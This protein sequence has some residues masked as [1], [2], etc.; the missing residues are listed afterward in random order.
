M[1]IVFRYLVPR[2]YSA[3][4]LFPFIFCKNNSYRN[5]SILINHE[6]IHLRQQLELLIIF[7]YIWYGLEYLYRLI[8][9]KNKQKAYY[10]ISFE[11]EAYKHEK[12]SN[13]LKTRPLYN[14]IKFI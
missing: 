2:N 4:A 3:I 8:L 10:S 7:F 13:Y 6:R 9:T 5:D 1:I 12:N 11:K 14:F